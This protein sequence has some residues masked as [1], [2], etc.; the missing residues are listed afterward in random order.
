MITFP[1]H[2]SLLTCVAY[3]LVF[4]VEVCGLYLLFIWS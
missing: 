4:N 3:I 1:E 2:S